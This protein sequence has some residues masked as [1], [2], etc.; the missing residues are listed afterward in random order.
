M[1][2]MNETVV[3]ILSTSAVTGAVIETV[4]LIGNWIS[5]RKNTGIT[6]LEREIRYLTTI[7]QDL[8]KNIHD[9]DESYKVILHDRLWSAYNTLKNAKSISLET[10]G[11]LDYLFEEYTHR[12]GNH[13]GELIYDLIKK[14]PVDDEP[15]E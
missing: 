3:A 1:S 14:I 11:N 5:K 12:N 10:R 13:K 2:Q 8:K 9:L 7:V 4:R 15:K 6:K